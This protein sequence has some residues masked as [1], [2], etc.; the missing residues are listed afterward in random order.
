MNYRGATRARVTVNGTGRPKK[1]VVITGG[2][3]F[4]GTNL[5]DRLLSDGERVVLFD[6]LSR[7][8]VERNYHGLNDGI[9]ARS[10]WSWQIRSISGRFIVF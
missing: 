2:A 5:A 3:G 8:G 4:I 1:P 9:G 7:A 6:N 10:N